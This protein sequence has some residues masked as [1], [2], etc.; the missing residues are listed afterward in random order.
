MSNEGFEG[1]ESA[2]TGST[3]EHERDGGR[4]A[5]DLPP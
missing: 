2:T 1:I 5:A 3:T 4:D